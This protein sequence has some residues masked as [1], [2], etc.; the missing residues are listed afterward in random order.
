[1]NDDLKVD[2]KKMLLDAVEAVQS[3][4]F[5]IDY[6]AYHDGFTCSSDQEALRKVLD[7]LYIRIG[8]LAVE[9]FSQKD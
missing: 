7:N 2:D 6:V 3:L 1:M 8:Y 5:A 4:T 9:Y